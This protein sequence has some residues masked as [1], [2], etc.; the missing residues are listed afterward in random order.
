[1][2]E[3]NGEKRA[4]RQLAVSEVTAGITRHIAENGPSFL[5]EISRHLT[6]QGATRKQVYRVLC[7][8]EDSGTLNTAV[9]ETTEESDREKVR[10]WV[11]RY[12]LATSMQ[13][14]A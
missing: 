5:K 12:D 3:E 7:D 2:A 11:K 13:R 4:P 14:A 10:G 8:M 9:V 1:M 6:E